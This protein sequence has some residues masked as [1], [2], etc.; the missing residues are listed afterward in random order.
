[1][2][3]LKK[4]IKALEDQ[5]VDLFE[6]APHLPKEVRDILITI[7][8]WCAII[9]GILGIVALFTASAFSLFLT[10][11]TFG[12]AIWLF[13]PIAIGFIA[14]VLSLMAFPGLKDGLKDGWDKLF[15][16]QIIS[17]VGVI[18]S[19]LASHFSLWS[20][21]GSAIGFYLLFEIRSHYK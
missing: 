3:E 6:K 9:F 17:A 4:H 1:M 16:S 5:L 11:A 20:I 13:I 8:P 14:A 7:A 19:I 12:L 15:L 10:I 21:V 2:T 18:A